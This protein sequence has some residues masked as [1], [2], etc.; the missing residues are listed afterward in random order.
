MPNFDSR[1]LQSSYKM[2]KMPFYR[3]LITDS[4]QTATSRI[5]HRLQLSKRKKL[6]IITQNVEQ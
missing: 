6:T 3:N 2:D 4:Y 5:S 1:M